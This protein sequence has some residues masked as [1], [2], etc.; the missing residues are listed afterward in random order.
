[1]LSGRV[2][3]VFPANRSLISAS[4]PVVFCCLLSY[5]SSSKCD[6]KILMCLHIY[7]LIRVSKNIIFPCGDF[8]TSEY[9]SIFYTL[10][11]TFF[12]FCK[13]TLFV[14]VWN[15]FFPSIGFFLKI[16]VFLLF[17]GGSWSGGEATATDTA[18][19]DASQKFPSDL[20]PHLL[21]FLIF[22]ILKL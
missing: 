21:H 4:H 3:C 8:D 13:F 16:F 17:Q 2:E 22:Y 9:V 14:C 7:R 19:D 11:L 1:M 20:L 5:R 10:P 6:M 18:L 15:I 12:V